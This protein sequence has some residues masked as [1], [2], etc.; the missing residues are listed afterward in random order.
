ML[1]RDVSKRPSLEEIISHPWITRMTGPAPIKTSAA[2]LATVPAAETKTPTEPV[3]P[4]TPKA[5]PAKS[6]AVTP[7]A[8]ASADDEEDG[9]E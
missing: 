4:A 7:S 2:A 8:G 5:A 9:M 6:C 1:Q 3:A